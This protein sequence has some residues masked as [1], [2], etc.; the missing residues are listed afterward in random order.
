MTYFGWKYCAGMLLTLCCSSFIRL[1]MLGL[2]DAARSTHTYTHAETSGRTIT[3]WY[4]MAQMDCEPQMQL[5]KHKTK[6]TTNCCAWK[7]LRISQV[8]RHDRQASIELNWVRT[9]VNL[10]RLIPKYSIVMCMKTTFELYKTSHQL[11]IHSFSSLTCST[12]E[13]GSNT[14]TTYS[15]INVTTWFTSTAVH[16]WM[17]NFTINRICSVPLSLHRLSPIQSALKNQD[18]SIRKNVRVH[19]YHNARMSC[20][21]SNFSDQQHYQHSLCLAKRFY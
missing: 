3:K 18:R 4:H 7:D 1:M 15:I 19:F 17:F 5:L 14:V 10:L 9:A 20:L 13:L 11:L 8:L 16:F 21:L 6:Q 2:A 12:S